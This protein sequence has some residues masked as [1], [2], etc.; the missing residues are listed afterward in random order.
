MPNGI[1]R[2]GA[3]PAGALGASVMASPYGPD[4]SA[5]RANVPRTSSRRPRMSRRPRATTSVNSSSVVENDEVGVGAG[6]Q[7]AFSGKF[8]ESRPDWRRK[9]R[10]PVPAPGCRGG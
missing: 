7:N 5:G 2:R 10:P 3:A 9:A 1:G 6:L 4:Q 8:V